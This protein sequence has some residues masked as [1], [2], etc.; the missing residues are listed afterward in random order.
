MTDRL[1]TA[2][3]EKIAD[4]LRP[5]PNFITERATIADYPAS[6]SEAVGS[7]PL[8]VANRAR[9][10]TALLNEVFPDRRDVCLSIAQRVCRR[11]NRVVA[12]DEIVLVRR[13]RAENKLCVGPRLEFDRFV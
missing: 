5:A 6:S 11:V 8:G 4:A 3:A 2:D 7:M 13:G 9:L 12:E 10:Q 1:P